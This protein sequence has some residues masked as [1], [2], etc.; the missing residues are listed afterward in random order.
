MMLHKPMII[1]SQTRGDIMDAGNGWRLTRQHKHV[2]PGKGRVLVVDDTVMTGNSQQILRKVVG[3]QFREVIFATV[4][5]NPAANLGKPDIHA[6]DLQW[7]HMLEWN[8]FN[9][10]ISNSMAVDFDGVLCH[11]CPPGSDEDG[12]KYLDFIRNA[13][14]LYLPRQVPIPLIVTARIEKYRRDTE[15]WLR[16]HNVQWEQLVM[17]PAA[18]TRERERDDIAVY[19]SRHFE[20]WA[21]NHRASPGPIVFVES[22][23]RQA[24]RIAAITGRMTICPATAGV[25]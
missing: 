14:P 24:Q 15:D 4:Y 5:C 2:E 23:D 8:L 17:H 7:P 19:K 18:T 11:D 6:V 1:V 21:K 20:A 10:V 9:S 12:P 13:T 16:R 3:Q 25:Y 22:D